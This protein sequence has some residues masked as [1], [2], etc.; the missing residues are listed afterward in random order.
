MFPRTWYFTFTLLLVI[1]PQPTIMEKLVFFLF[2]Q[3][4]R[5]PQGTEL[6]YCQ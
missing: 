2:Q 6:D 4:F 1:D 5:S 3:N